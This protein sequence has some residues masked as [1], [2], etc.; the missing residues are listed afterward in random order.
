MKKIFCVLMLAFMMAA[1]MAN[2]Q[3][4]KIYDFDDLTVSN[5]SILNSVTTTFTTPPIYGG[6]NEL[7]ATLELT[8]ASGTAGGTCEIYKSNFANT[9]FVLADTTTFTFINTAT[10]GI[11]WS[12]SA[13]ALYYRVVCEPSGTMVVIPRM[14]VVAKKY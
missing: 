1:G 5:D 9:G 7:S 8:K 3:S 2:G 4:F 13:D 11:T 12:S 10:Q 6:F 14:R